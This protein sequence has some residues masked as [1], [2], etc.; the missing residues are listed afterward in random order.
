MALKDLCTEEEADKGTPVELYHP[1]NGTPMGIVIVMLGSDSQAFLDAER[2]IRNRQLEL[3]KKKRDF[4]VG[5]EPEA[6]EAALVEKMTA[7]F[8]GWKELVP[9]H[10]EAGQK[11]PASWK[12][13]VEFE[14]GVELPSTK[15]EFKKI[16]SRRGFFWLRQQVQ[17][18]MDDV[19]RFLPKSK[20]SSGLQ[21]TIDS[22]TR[23]PEK[24][25]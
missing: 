12:D 6:V 22:S 10:E 14:P 24:M 3:G 25:E 11:V 2:K 16:I 7:C 17:T 8:V 19:T 9:E 23:H 5:M 20:A 1:G 4:T 21:P 15:E 18:A 13:T